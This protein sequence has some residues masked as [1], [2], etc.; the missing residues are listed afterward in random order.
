MAIQFITG[1]PRQGKGIFAADLLW[2]ALTRTKRCIITTLAIDLD[3]L[4]DA[5]R[6][7]GFNIHVASRVLRLTEREAIQHFWRH[8]ACRI[9]ETVVEDVTVP[10]HWEWPIV[11]GM[12]PDAKG[13]PQMAQ[14]GIEEPGVLYILDEVHI[15]FST[16]AWRS[17]GVEAM[18]YVS[19]HAHWG[20]DL[21]LIT[22]R[23]G[24]VQPKLVELAE[25]FHQMTNYGKRTY[26]GMAAGK[27]FKRLSWYGEPRLGQVADNVSAFRLPKIVTEGGWYSSKGGIGIETLAGGSPDAASTKKG[28]PPWAW[29]TAGALA[30]FLVSR[31]VVAGP[32]LL[33]ARVFGMGVHKPVAV[34]ASV[35]PESIVLT[36]H[37]SAGVSMSKDVQPAKLEIEVAT[38]WGIA[39]GVLYWNGRKIPGQRIG[40]M[41]LSGSR[42]PIRLGP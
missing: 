28:I 37:L 21:I 18:W 20:D 7:N 11:P 35:V 41:W 33:F 38:N 3:K 14:I 17:Y 36:N 16:A 8:R 27:W 22:Q 4:Q 32:R 6:A 12:D 29:I 24:Q 30:V 26:H 9:I 31:I 2:K 1:L 39:N 13:V 10:Q 5:C 23:V 40:D 34:A 25:E 42:A 19:Q 15:H